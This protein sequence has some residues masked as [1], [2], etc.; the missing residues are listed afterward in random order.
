MILLDT[1][2]WSVLSKPAGEERVAV[3]I[4]ERMNDAWLSVIAIAEIRMGIDHAA[5]SKRD[6]LERWLADLLV[7]CADRILDFDTA[8]AQIFGALV[9]RRKMQ[10]QETKLLDIQLAAQA[11]AHDCPVATRNVKDFA[12]TGATLVNPWE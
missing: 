5:E 8:S 7:L 3:W 12:W 6:V 4:S 10:K 9:A 11:I 2:V 1:N